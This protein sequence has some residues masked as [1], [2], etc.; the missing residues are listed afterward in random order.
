MFSVVVEG[1]EDATEFNQDYYMD[2][3]EETVTLTVTNSAGEK[4]DYEC[5]GVYLRD[6][7]SV[8]GAEEYTSVKVVAADYEQTFDAALVNEDTTF[9]AIEV[10]GSTEDCPTILA[11]SK[12]SK[13][14]V[15]SVIQLVIE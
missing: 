3:S 2:M 9:F 11:A 15:K 6:V 12:G 14:I 5:R 1:L 4:K 7:M 13:Y 8:L 10:N